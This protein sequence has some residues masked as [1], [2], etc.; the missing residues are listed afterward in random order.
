MSI[1]S[2]MSIGT[3]SMQAGNNRTAIAAGKIAGGISNDPDAAS[4]M[5]EL[6]RGAID[7]EAAATIVKT[8][9]QML[10]SL[11]NLRA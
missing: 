10:G 6:N 8:G 7:T 1:G 11:I 5:L 2:I 4:T 3:Q 9:D